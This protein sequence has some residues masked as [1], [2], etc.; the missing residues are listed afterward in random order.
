MILQLRIHPIFTAELTFC[1]AKVRR[2]A[3]HWEGRWV[4]KGVYRLIRRGGTREVEAHQTTRMAPGSAVEQR[5][6]TAL[7]LSVNPWCRGVEINPS[8]VT[9]SQPEGCVPYWGN[10]GVDLYW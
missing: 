8:S 7:P 1:A 4:Y 10:S 5:A 3:E 9:S 6:R 2:A